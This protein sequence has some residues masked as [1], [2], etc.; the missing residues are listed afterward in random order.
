MGLATQGNGVRAEVRSY[1]LL[2]ICI[3]M[4]DVTQTTTQITFSSPAGGIVD[5]KPRFDLYDFLTQASHVTTNQR[6]RFGS[7]KSGA[8]TLSLA[9]RASVIATV[10]DVTFDPPS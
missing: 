10:C 6:T 1:L 5:C 2:T 3:P 7:P 8:V 9:L 4:S